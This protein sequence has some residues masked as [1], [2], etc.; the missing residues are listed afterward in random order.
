MPLR[1][2]ASLRVRHYHVD[3]AFTHSSTGGMVISSL[4]LNRFM[5]ER[6]LL[7]RYP[8]EPD[9]EPVYRFDCHALSSFFTFA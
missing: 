9:A 7:V 3:V 1:A 8:R 2:T 4:R 5:F 6:C